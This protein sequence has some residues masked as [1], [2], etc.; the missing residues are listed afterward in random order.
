LKEEET[1]NGSRRVRAILASLFLVVALVLASCSQTMMRL[2]TGPRAWVGGPP[3]GSE[4]PLGMV[5]AMCHA[6]AKAGVSHIELWVNG[7]F[8]NR[9]PNTTDP[10]AEYFTASLTF[11]TTGPG[12]YVLHCWTYDQDG[13]SAQSDP[14]TLRVTGEEPTPTTGEEEIP[15]A[16]PTSTEVPPTATRPSPSETAVPPT[17]TSIPP[18][19]TRVP[20]TSTPRPPTATPVPVRIVSFEVSESQ[21]TTGGCVR[22]D[23]VVQGSP[24]A[25]FFDG[26]GV[27]SPDSRDRCPT[28][29]R[30]YELRAE[31]NGQ[32]ADRATLTVVVVQGDT[33]GPTITRVAD[34]PDPIWWHENTPCQPSTLYPNQV[35]ISARIADESGVYAAKVTY[36]MKGGSWQSVG[37]SQVQT[38][39]YSATIGAN[40]L[41]LSLNP[42]VGQTYGAVNS[43]EYYVQAFDQA[44]NRT[45]S[46]SRTVTVE[47][48]Y[49]VT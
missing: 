30:E 2:E 18:T 10:S 36:R 27:S 41:E 21:T 8:A 6:Y 32:V 37:M 11:E 45:D 14:V 31:L 49:I 7:V 42:P 23:W 15:T 39:W 29:T 1:M 13:G 26:E 47:Y 46:P 43:L 48:C 28:A 17:A 19:S 38:G 24:S 9:A 44:N 12:S 25:I 5:S 4:V 34:S 33:T 22:F 16:S 40:Q 3:D 20:P 35:T